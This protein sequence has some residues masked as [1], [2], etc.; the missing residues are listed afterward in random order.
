MKC[1]EVGHE[2]EAADRGFGTIKVLSRTDKT[3]TVQNHHGNKFR[4]KLRQNDGVEYVYDMS[5]GRNWAF[6]LTYR[7]DWDCEREE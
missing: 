4:M 5:F 1:F 7:A 3:V 6:A 2:Y